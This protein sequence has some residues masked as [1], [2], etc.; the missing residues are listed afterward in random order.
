MVKHKSTERYVGRPDKWSLS[1]AAVIAMQ[2]SGI[3][4]HTM[5]RH[6]VLSMIE[7]AD[8]QAV[9]LCYVAQFPYTTLTRA[10]FSSCAI[11]DAVFV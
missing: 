5:S 11:R 8:H 7:P 4:K 9:G 2:F 10:C 1:F 6:I 3:R